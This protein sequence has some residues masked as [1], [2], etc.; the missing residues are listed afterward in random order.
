M[1][2]SAFFRLAAAKTR[3]RAAA[4]GAGWQT[5]PATTSAASN[6]AQL[7]PFMPRRSDRVDEAAGFG[8]DGEGDDRQRLILRSEQR[9]LVELDVAEGDLG[10]TQPVDRRVTLNADAGL[11]GIDEKEADPRRLARAAGGARRDD[12]AVGAFA[13]Q[14]HALLTAEHEAGGDRLRRGR[15]IGEVVAR[16]PLGMGEGEAEIA[17]GDRRDHLLALRRAA[18]KAKEAAA[19][20]DRREVRLEHEAASE[21][22]HDDHR[23]DRRAADA[24]Q[25]FGE[26]QAEQAELGILRPAR[27]AVAERLLRIGLALLEG[28][29][30][31]DQAGD[32]V[33]EQALLVAEVE[34]HLPRDPVSP[35]R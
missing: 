25:L 4:A 9:V 19:E 12:D 28:V 11:L 14:H 31:V 18:G 7:V 32:R 17:G 10:G 22:F 16:L 34:I 35:S 26:G 20:H 29:F 2:S 33:L 1:S 5:N 24:A 27:F 3:S 15:D 30:L 21:G 8:D 13:V 6:R 23:L